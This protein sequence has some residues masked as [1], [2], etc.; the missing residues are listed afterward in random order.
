MAGEF[1][2]SE[3]SHLNSVLHYVFV[4]FLP[5]LQTELGLWHGNY[6]NGCPPY[7][8]LMLRKIS[9][10]PAEEFPT[11]DTNISYMF[12]N[13]NWIPLWK[14]RRDHSLWSWLGINPYLTME[15]MCEGFLSYKLKGSGFVGR[16]ICAH[17]SEV[18]VSRWIIGMCLKFPICY[19][20]R[21][22]NFRNRVMKILSL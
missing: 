11:F 8:Q 6:G 22:A 5:A 14:V 3:K 21:N 20:Q 9:V 4:S 18:W 15:R 12:P 19:P 2:L 13:P 10:A 1:L 7:L 17:L 16:H